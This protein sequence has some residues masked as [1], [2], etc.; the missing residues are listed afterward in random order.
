MHPE[1]Y[2]D[3]RDSVQ[4]YMY[5]HD[6]RLLVNPMAEGIALNGGYS[7]SFAFTVVSNISIFAHKGSNCLSD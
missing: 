6:P 1:Q 4:M 7:Y 5:V 2:M 3:S